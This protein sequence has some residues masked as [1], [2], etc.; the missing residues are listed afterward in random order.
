M[1]NLQHYA[2]S[3]TLRSQNFY[4]RHYPIG[5]SHVTTIHMHILN[6]H[7]SVHS[8]TACPQIS[9]LYISTF[10]PLHLSHTH[11]ISTIS[12]VTPVH[13]SYLQIISS[14]TINLSFPVSSPLL[15]WR[16]VPSV[17][18]L[19]V[20]SS[21]VHPVFPNVLIVLSTLVSSHNSFKYLQTPLTMD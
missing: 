3:S 6:F 2:G 19:L 13:L 12:I 10:L 1:C 9:S 15:R 8:T 5:S 11:I 18:N 20:R 17:S 16:T 4:N 21:S 7:Y 14:Y